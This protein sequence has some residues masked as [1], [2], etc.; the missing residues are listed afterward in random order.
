L[1]ALADY[2]ETTVK[3]FME[4]P[5]KLRMVVDTAYQV[6][7]LTAE[8]REGIKAQREAIHG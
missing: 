4:W 8:V 3:D 2:A 6:G 5:R 7:K 1:K